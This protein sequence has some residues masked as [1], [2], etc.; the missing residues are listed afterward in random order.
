MNKNYFKNIGPGALI[1]AAFIGPG[2]VTACT[3]AG[4]NYGYTLLWAIAI[5]IIATIILQEMSARAGLVTRTGLAALI[6]KSISSSV[7]R[8]MILMIVFSAI[9]IGNAAYEAGNLTGG[10]LGVQAL[11]P[12]GLISS[13]IIIL[14]LGFLA[15]GLLWAGNYKILERVLV[16]LVLTMSIAFILTALITRPNIKAILVGVFAFNSPPGSLLTVLGLVGTTVV[17]YNLFLH[18]SIVQK[19]WKEPADLGAVR[20]DTIVSIFLGGLVSMAVMICA[21]PLM[22]NTINSAGDLAQGLAPLLGDFAKYFL[23]IGLLAA[24]LTSAITA[25]LAAAFVAAGC[26]G[27]DD[28]LRAKRFRMIWAMVLLL[29]VASSFLNIK[30]LQLIQFA[31]VANG[32]V[33]PLIAGILLWVMNNSKVLGKYKNNVLQNCLGMIVFLFACFLGGRGIYRVVS[34]FW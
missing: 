34:S 19:R 15:G 27:W 23:G 11:L 20:F 12:E 8:K 30:P 28:D 1:A 29:G 10:V 32:L 6:R 2:T 4:V 31:Q 26:F 16:G 21:V 9:V 7:L 13:K 5:S 3:L 14:L 33:L 18:A 22:G 24:G 25:P 17:P